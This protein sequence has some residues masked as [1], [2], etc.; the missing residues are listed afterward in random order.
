M[1]KK[2][3]TPSI[4]RVHGKRTREAVK[5]RPL[6]GD[7]TLSSSE[8]DGSDEE[9]TA[10]DGVRPWLRAKTSFAPSTA[11]GAT[12]TGD[13]PNA[14]SKDGSALNVE[15][16]KA[17]IK[18]RKA[19]SG[20]LASPDYSDVE[21][22]VAAA[23]LAR[24]ESRHAPGW[25]PDFMRQHTA[26]STS[27]GLMTPGG[28]ERGSGLTTAPATPLR[29]VPATPSLIRAIERV[30]Q[31]QEVAYGF[32]VPQPPAKIEDAALLANAGDEQEKGERWVSFWRDVKQKAN[33]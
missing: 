2:S 27:G 17:A 26:R 12:L 15:K 30:N 20:N 13:A 23:T 24:R 16:E 29:S 10:K 9:R 1:K 28:S 8:D 19:D 32:P 18:Q 5:F 6:A 21:E 14:G 4:P 3:T 7:E 11:S 25:S 31:A 33:S 22:D